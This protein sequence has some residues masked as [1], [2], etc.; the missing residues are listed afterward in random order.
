MAEK[1]LRVVAPGEAPPK[2]RRPKTVTEAAK[3]GTHRDLL[4]AMR[5]RVARAVEDSTTPARD[6]AALTRRL[7]ELARDIE[8]IDARAA[9]EAGEGGDVQDGEFDAAAI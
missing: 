5:E 2:P 6:L 3:D 9:E 7:M 1:S 8:A 4:V